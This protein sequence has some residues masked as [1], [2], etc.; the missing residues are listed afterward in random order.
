MEKSLDSLTTESGPTIPGDRPLWRMARLVPTLAQ[1]ICFK[2][3]TTIIPQQADLFAR[4]RQSRASRDT[5]ASSNAPVMY[6]GVCSNPYCVLQPLFVP[7]HQ[8]LM[9]RL[10]ALSLLFSSACSNSGQ[11]LRAHHCAESTCDLS[12]LENKAK[13]RRDDALQAAGLVACVALGK[14]GVWTVALTVCASAAPIAPFA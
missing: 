5:H 11:K 13:T 14:G 4:L 12:R 6:F 9:P 10:L 1:N 2:E 8:G 3:M 7:E